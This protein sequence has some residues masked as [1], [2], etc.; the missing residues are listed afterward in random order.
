[1]IYDVVQH[2]S[3]FSSNV[4]IPQSIK[5][6]EEIQSRMKANEE[7]LGFVSAYID[8]YFETH[9]TSAILLSLAKILVQKFNLKLD[10]LAKRNRSAMLCWYSENWD[11][12]L[13]YLRQG[14][15]NFTGKTP[16]TPQILIHDQT[17]SP[18]NHMNYNMDPTDITY[19]LNQH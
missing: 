18:M 5:D 3:E 17:V 9:V 10:R 8:R 1:M 11:K 6:Y 15:P 16:W 14:K 7:K 2:C 4:K 13:P 19:L 12:I